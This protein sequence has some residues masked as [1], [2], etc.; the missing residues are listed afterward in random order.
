MTGYI[1]ELRKIVGQVC[2]IQCGA[3]VIVVNEKGELLLQRRKDNN[4]WGFHGGGVEPN[5]VVEDAARREL[6][7]ETGL[8]ADKLELF[9]VFSGPDMHYTYPNGDE[10]SNIDI[11]Y[12]CRSYSGDLKAQES[13][14]TELR[15]F[16]LAELPDNISPPQQKVLR[17]YVEHTGVVLPC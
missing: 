2:L 9:G 7:E 11:V 8:V 5:E 13:E 6:Y 3:T 14:V 17:S 15:F 10:V 4:C 16:A 12:I 1:T